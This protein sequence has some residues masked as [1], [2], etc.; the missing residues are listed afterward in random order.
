MNLLIMTIYIGTHDKIQAKRAQ[1]YPNSGF[2][3]GQ[4]T[5]PSLTD[6]LITNF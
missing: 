6:Q 3:L 5:Q 4:F 2:E 1:A